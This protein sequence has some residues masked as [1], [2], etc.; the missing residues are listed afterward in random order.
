MNVVYLVLNLGNFIVRESL[1]L[2][3]FTLNV[4]HHMQMMVKKKKKLEDWHKMT[5][6]IAKT[7][8]KPREKE[9]GTE[10]R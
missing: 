3:L 7:T 5:N 8:V 9:N 4:F 10:R 6:E 1:V 2:S